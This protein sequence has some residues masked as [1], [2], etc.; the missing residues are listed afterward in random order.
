MNENL[1]SFVEN[2]VSAVPQSIAK[3]FLSKISPQESLRNNKDFEN[4][5]SDE[6]HSLPQLQIH[7]PHPFPT[8]SSNSI[9]PINATK[10]NH[11]NQEEN[12][13]ELTKVKKA[14]V[15]LGQGI[16]NLDSSST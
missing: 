11:Q 7:V 8:Y 13:K 10:S 6:E 5:D 4:N 16:V 14:S 2:E 3:L 9:V 12:S 1:S 15:V